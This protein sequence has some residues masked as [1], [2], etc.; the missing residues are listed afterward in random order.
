MKKLLKKILTDKKMRNLNAMSA[1]LATV[2]SVGAPWF[3]K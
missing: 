3:D 1:F 2:A